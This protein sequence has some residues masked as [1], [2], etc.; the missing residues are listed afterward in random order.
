A[1]TVPILLSRTVDVRSGPGTLAA[2]PAAL[3]VGYAFVRFS[4]TLF[5]ELRDVVFVRASQT[6]VADY[7][8]RVFRHMLAWGARFHAN[9][10]TGA[11]TRDVE[12][13][14]ASIV[15]LLD[16]ALF[17]NVPPFVGMLSVVA[18]LS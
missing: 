15:F 11:R 14:R 16:V 18:I 6:T 10:S 9:R 17:A 1:V 3:L 5:G 7:T 2:V 8:V 4:T 12:R 13:G